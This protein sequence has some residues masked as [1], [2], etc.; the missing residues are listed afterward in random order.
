MFGQAQNGKVDA[1]TGFP[2]AHPVVWVNRRITDLGTL[3]G[4]QGAAGAMNLVGQAVGASL[5]RKPDPNA[6]SPMEACL[7]LPDNG[8]DAGTCELAVNSFLAPATTETH[9][10]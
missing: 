8:T 2:E 4:T 3:G 7:S 1:A 10:T 6:E 5:N 9:A